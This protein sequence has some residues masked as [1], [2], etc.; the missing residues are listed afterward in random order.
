VPRRFTQV[1]VFGGERL[2]GNPVAVVHDAEVLT[3][4][5]MAV[6]ARWTNLSETTFLLPPTDPRAD[7]RVRIFTPSA[8]LPFAGHPT[9][10]STHAWL[11]AGGVPANDDE[12][13]QQCD[14][15]LVRV[16]I[17]ERLEFAA[18]P[19]RRSGPLD[20]STLGRV[21]EAL[22]ITHDQV[23]GAA[24]VDNGA[25]FLGVRLP[26]AASVLALEPD[27]HAFGELEIGVIGAYA[28][29]DRARVGA[30]VEVRAFAPSFSVPEDP[31]TGS[32]NAGLAQWLIGS[33]LLPTSYVA[34]Q[35]TRMRRM[36]RVYVSAADGDIW[37]GGATTTII[38]GRASL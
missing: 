30:D 13:V 21:V 38:T 7:Y 3:D 8:E 17:G 26:D 9:L 34:S 27:F 16:R 14:A 37:I 2:L 24:W 35:G 15:G 23:L 12:V 32:L 6:F 31:V 28:A 33:G 5:Q 10:G 20:E 4:A 1:D 29:S 19:L 22:R 25:G 36:G 18:P 11:L